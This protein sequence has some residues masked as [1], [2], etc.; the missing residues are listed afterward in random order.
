MTAR[1]GSSL[2]P[3]QALVPRLVLRLHPKRRSSSHVMGCINPNPWASTAPVL[4][5]RRHRPVEPLPGGA[6]AEGTMIRVY[7][8]GLEK[9]REYHDWK[10]LVKVLV[11]FRAKIVDEIEHF[12]SEVNPHSFQFIKRPLLA[13]CECN[14]EGGQ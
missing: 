2:P 7:R 10:Y 6:E 1:L 12:I 3:P 8:G 13:R 9:H 14:D 11:Y 5:V 4:L